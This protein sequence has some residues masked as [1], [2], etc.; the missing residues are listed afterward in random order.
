MRCL[1]LVQVVLGFQAKLHGRD[2]GSSTNVMLFILFG[3]LNA[4]S[5]LYLDKVVIC[6]GHLDNIDFF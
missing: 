3:V 1:V 5:I 2:S 4:P 6:L